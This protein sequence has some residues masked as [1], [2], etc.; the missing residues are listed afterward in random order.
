MLSNPC[1]YSVVT[2]LVSVAF[3]TRGG[4]PFALRE[5]AIHFARYLKNQSR[6]P[7]G[8]QHQFLAL[9]W[10]DYGLFENRQDRN[11]QFFMANRFPLLPGQNYANLGGKRAKNQNLKNLSPDLLL[12]GI[13][14]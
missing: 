1:T 12:G 6:F 8:N 11:M 14:F 5:P 9:T 2:D 13:Y 3:S 4:G 7:P 10:S